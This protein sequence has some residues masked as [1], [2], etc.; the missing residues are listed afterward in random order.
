MIQAKVRGE[1]KNEERD[2]KTS[3]SVPGDIYS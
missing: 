3:I 2:R 1:N